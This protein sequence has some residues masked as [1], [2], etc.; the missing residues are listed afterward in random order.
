MNKINIRLFEEQNL[1]EADKVFRLAFGTF[2][3]L[4]D[5]MKI[6]SDKCKDSGMQNRNKRKT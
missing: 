2:L 4:V 1:S 5:P 6:F 3:G